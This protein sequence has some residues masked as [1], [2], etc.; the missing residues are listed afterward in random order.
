MAPAYP[1]KTDLLNNTTGG[2]HLPPS[3]QTLVQQAATPGEPSPAPSPGEP[4]LPPS[5]PAPLTLCAPSPGPPEDVGKKPGYTQFVV[6]V[7]ES[8]GAPVT[9]L[10]QT[11][12]VV[13][14]VSQRFPIEY[15][16]ESADA[17]ISIVIAIDTSGSMEPKL[18]TVNKTLGEFLQN[19]NPC[20]ELAII[21]FSGTASPGLL[22]GEPPILQSEPPIRLLQPFTTDRALAS[23]RLNT[24]KPHG[25]TPLYDAVHEGL[26][27]L[28]TAH[29]PGRALIV[30][31]DGI[32][33]S[34]T[35]SENDIV[36]EAAKD[37]WSVYPIGIGDPNAAG[38]PSIAIGSSVVIPGDDIQRVDAHALI[39]IASASGGRAFIVPPISK[40]GGHA[41]IEAIGAIGSMLGKDYVI[42]AILPPGTGWNANQPPIVAVNSR[43]A[44][45]A[46]IERTAPP[47]SAS[48]AQ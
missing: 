29:Y 14:S 11:D 17:P 34:S 38:T 37:G 40:D 19:L 8:S 41:F 45:I 9:G 27:L 23:S 28:G 4:S 21:S 16:R 18:A 42:G 31:T 36:A 25:D 20:D 33:N 15:F 47:L 44:A 10:Q 24:L 3:Y 22:Q 13:Y 26:R 32:D 35:I 39:E 7:R 30:V 12:F 43:P 6:S 5:P 2:N 1:S 46:H 48:A